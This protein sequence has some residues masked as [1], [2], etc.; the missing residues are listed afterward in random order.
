[1]MLKIGNVYFPLSLQKCGTMYLMDMII[2]K[3]LYDCKGYFL[4]MVSTI[5]E[6]NSVIHHQEPRQTTN[7]DNI[8][9]VVEISVYSGDITSFIAN[10]DLFLPNTRFRSLNNQPLSLGPPTNSNSPK[11][12]S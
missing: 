8:F 1:M 12:I 3:T 6:V 9:F 2:I 5:M 11:L 10:P 4:I 7:S